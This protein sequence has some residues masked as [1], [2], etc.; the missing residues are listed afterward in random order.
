MSLGRFHHEQG[1][2]N[3]CLAACITMIRLR[4]G[5]LP[6][7]DAAG[8]EQQLCERLGA[9][10]GGILVD[11]AAQEIGSRTV[12]ADPEAPGT[13]IVLHEDLASG[14]W[15]HIV[16]LGAAALATHQQDLG[17]PRSRYGTLS[18]LPHAVVL[19]GFAAGSLHYLDPWFDAEGQPHTMPI[20]VF[21]GAWTGMFIP[22]AIP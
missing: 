1:R 5:A 13:Y 16:I 20:D 9:G 22:V 3:S 21:A 18:G 10:R 11:V 8:H 2:S 4:V 7:A 12:I 15:W 14:R 6:P 19:V 17:L